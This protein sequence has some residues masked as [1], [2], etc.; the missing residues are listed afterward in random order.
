[1]TDTG[2]GASIPR[3]EDDRFLCGRGQFVG[4]IKLAG[5]LDAAFLRSPV[6]HGRLISVQVPEHLHNLVFTSKDLVNVKPVRAVSGLPGFKTS[7]Q[8]VLAENKLRWVGELLAVCLGE[9]RATAEDAA[10]EVF[11]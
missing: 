2:V 9:T 5:M 11:A 6:A 3:K 10:D 1:M 7:E 4:D 8:P